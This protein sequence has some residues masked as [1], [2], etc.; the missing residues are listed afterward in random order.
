MIEMENMQRSKEEKDIE[1]KMRLPTSSLNRCYDSKSFSAMRNTSLEELQPLLSKDD[2]EG[3]MS[4]SLAQVDHRD[5]HLITDNN[6]S[7]G[8]TTFDEIDV[9][10]ETVRESDASNKEMSEKALMRRRMKNQRK[11]KN[12]RQRNQSQ[13]Q[14][15]REGEVR[16]DDVCVQDE[17][18]GSGLE[19]EVKT[20]FQIDNVSDS[21][22]SDFLNEKSLNGTGLL[23]SRM[24]SSENIES[25]YP[26]PH[27][28]D[29]E[30]PSWSN[31]SPEQVISVTDTSGSN[32]AQVFKK[33]LSKREKR[34]Q[35]QADLAR[36]QKNEE[37]INNE[38]ASPTIAQVFG[39]YTRT[40]GDS[41]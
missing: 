3:G 22:K 30:Q 4:N 8:V 38:V 9:V 6:P 21:T 25:E 2:R 11:K 35:Q 31:Q 40:R 27:Q 34:L 15:E 32:V 10:L 12:A 33:K 39:Y 16:G 7:K 20:V 14:E 41:L 26:H 37:V 36:G 28:S 23:S 1:H 13:G 17:V 24:I 19:Q 29:V 18:G 5:E